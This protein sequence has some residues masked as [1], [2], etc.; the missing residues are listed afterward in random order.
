MSMDAP[1]IPFFQVHTAP[2]SVSSGETFETPVKYWQSQ[3]VA[4]LFWVDFDSANQLVSEMQV[5]RFPQNR[6]LLTVGFFDYKQTTIRPY[7][8]VGVFITVMPKG[9]EPP[10]YPILGAILPSAQRIVGQHTI[11]LPVTTELARRAGIEKAG[12]PKFVTDIDFSLTQQKFVGVVHDPQ[13]GKESLVS[14][15]GEFGALVPAPWPDMV[16]LH[17]FQNRPFRV[18]FE[19]AQDKL[20]YLSTSG[21]FALNWSKTSEHAM[22][23]NLTALKLQDTRPFLVTFIE[24]ANILFHPGAFFDK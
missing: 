1:N 2:N 23:K 3:G 24:D 11:N 15:Q 18:I 13:G 6:A 5:V 22:A 9:V 12:M 7:K 8:E 16:I 10:Q 19:F 21:T 20:G 14:M 17:K 4:A